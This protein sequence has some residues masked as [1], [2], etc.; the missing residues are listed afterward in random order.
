MHF[1]DLGFFDLGFR[2]VA[3]LYLIT[4]TE[5]KYFICEIISDSV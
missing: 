4:A 1:I 5:L 2:I 3:I